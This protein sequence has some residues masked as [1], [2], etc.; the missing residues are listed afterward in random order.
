MQM[1]SEGDLQIGR[2]DM[3]RGGPSNDAGEGT[4]PYYLS[5]AKPGPKSTI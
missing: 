3:G 2:L 5:T 1:G 4:M